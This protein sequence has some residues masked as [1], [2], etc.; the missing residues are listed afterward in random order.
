MQKLSV[1]EDL[2]FLFGPFTEEELETFLSKNN[3][4]VEVI[5]LS[6]EN[7][8]GSSRGTHRKS[9]GTWVTVRRIRPPNEFD[10]PF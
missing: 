6:E 10:Y 2:G 8:I 9:N 1:V 5:D 4:T 3:I 7:L